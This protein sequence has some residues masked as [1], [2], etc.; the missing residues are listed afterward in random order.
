MTTLILVRHGQT[1]W[2]REKRFRGQFDIP[3]NQTGMEQARIT[4]AR[5]DR[6]YQ[7]AAVY[8]SPL[9][10]AVKTAEIIAETLG[11]TASIHPDLLDIDYGEL[12]GLNGEEA[13]NAFPEVMRLWLTAPGQA[14][15]PNGESLDAVR[16][17][18][19]RF[20]KFVHTEHE[21]QAIVAVGHT[22]I[23]RILLL[24]ILGLDNDRLWD[25]G[26]SNCAINLL[27]FT[28]GHWRIIS[29]NDIGHLQ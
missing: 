29:L 8:A 21:S 6:N 1:E 14:H 18:A 9:G 20:L 4:A 10:R 28:K 25:L 15:F 7:P 12:K 2:N 26:Q 13:H 22:V 17:R 24:S 19:D 27:E 3:L 16:E 5:I 11:L 23:N